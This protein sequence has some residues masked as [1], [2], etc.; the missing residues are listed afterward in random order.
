[1]QAVEDIRGLLDALGHRPG[2]R[3]RAFDGR[4]RDAALRADH[5][6]SRAVAGCRGRGLWQRQ[7][8]GGVPRDT[9]TVVER[10][11]GGMEAVAEFYSRGP[12]RVQFQDKDPRGWQEFRYRL[13]RGSAQGTRAH[14]DGACR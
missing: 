9:A 12:T 10:F 14:P 6:A 4:L 11:K 7:G 8:P 13:G 2:A 5:P 3:L 1:M